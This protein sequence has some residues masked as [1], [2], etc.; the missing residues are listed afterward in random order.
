MNPADGALQTGDVVDG[1]N[2][3]QPGIPGRR[4]VRV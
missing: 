1:T 4:I 3:G 2:A